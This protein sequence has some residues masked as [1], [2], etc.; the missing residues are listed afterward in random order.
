MALP[1][2]EKVVVAS[3][4]VAGVESGTRE[5]RAA[6]HLSLRNEAIGDSPLIEHLDG[7]YMQPACAQAVE[8]LTFAPLDNRDVDAR[9][10]QLAR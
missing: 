10:G 1:E 4:E 5:R 3:R 9:Q 2:R 7:T 6:N 8:I